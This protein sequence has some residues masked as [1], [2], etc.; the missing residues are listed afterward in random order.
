MLY[1]LCFG[2]VWVIMVIG[3]GFELG[4]LSLKKGQTLKS[5]PMKRFME[6]IKSNTDNDYALSLILGDDPIDDRLN[7]FVKPVWEQISMA[8]EII[9]NDPKLANG[10]HGL[11][12]SQGG[13]FLRAV[14]QTCPEERFRFFQF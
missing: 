5:V 4:L 1:L 12:F 10:Y 13:Q 9:A 11:G 8:C 14:A 3:M 6:M 2:M 7:G